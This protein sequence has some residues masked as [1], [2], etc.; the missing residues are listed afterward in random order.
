MICRPYQ[1]V[2]SSDVFAITTSR[3][4]PSTSCAYHSGKVSLSPTVTNTPYGSTELRRSAAPLG[5]V[6][7]PLRGAD[8]RLPMRGTTASN[9]T[10][11]AISQ[12]RVAASGVTLLSRGF[13]ED[14]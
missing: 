5:V 1:S 10:G 6:V 12:L 7:C 8:E 9:A 13:A 2:F 11:D 14:T 3:R 4:M